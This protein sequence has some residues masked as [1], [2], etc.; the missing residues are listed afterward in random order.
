M[1]VQK[2]ETKVTEVIVCGICKLEGTLHDGMFLNIPDSQF[3]KSCLLEFYY[4]NK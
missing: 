1:I 3:H 4:K 2:T